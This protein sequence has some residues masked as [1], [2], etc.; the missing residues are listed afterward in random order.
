[1]IAY[2]ETAS[3]CSNYRALGI[4]LNG[5]FAEYVRIPASAVRAG[6]SQEIKGQIT[7]EE[8]VI[9]EAPSCVHNGS[10]QCHIK[11]GET[12]LDGDWSR[13]NRRYACN[14][15]QDGRRWKSDN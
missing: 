15:G 7:F 8:A 2:V 1:M 12:V 10:S 5:G 3:M 6:N 13:P 4:N 14:D 11:P 9:T